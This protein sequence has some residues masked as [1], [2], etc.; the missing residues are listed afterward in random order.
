[1]TVPFLTVTYIKL[2]EDSCDS[3]YGK[4]KQVFSSEIQDFLDMKL[5]ASKGIDHYKWCKTSP[6][7]IACEELVKKF[8]F[9]FRYFLIDGQK[10]LVAKYESEGIRRKGYLGLMGERLRPCVP[11]PQGAA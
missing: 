4:F 2:P 9:I 3:D 10:F 6:Y 7:T 1:M 11:R 5:S 8:L